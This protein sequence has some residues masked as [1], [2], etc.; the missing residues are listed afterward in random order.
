[1][2][3]SSPEPSVTLTSYRGGGGEGEANTL[4]RP[5]LLESA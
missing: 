5:A 1:V 2:Y 4:A 3:L